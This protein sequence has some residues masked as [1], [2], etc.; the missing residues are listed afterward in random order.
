MSLEA[1]RVAPGRPW[2]GRPGVV[3]VAFLLLSAGSACERG[4]RER[5]EEAEILVLDEDTVRLAPG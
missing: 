2:I 5:V 4:E 3:L 1:V